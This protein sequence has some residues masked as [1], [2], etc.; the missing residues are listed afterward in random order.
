MNLAMCWQYLWYS[1]IQFIDMQQKNTP[2]IISYSNFLTNKLRIRYVIQW[3]ESDIHLFLSLYSIS[4]SLNF[5]NV[6]KCVVRSRNVVVSIN[7]IPYS[8]RSHRIQRR[9]TR[10][11][12]WR[13]NNK[14][15][16]SFEWLNFIL[17]FIFRFIFQ[18]EKRKREIKCGINMYSYTDPKYQSYTKKEEE[19][20]KI[21]FLC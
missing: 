9:K 17:S 13:V 18:Y 3:I 11:K 19:E 14:N 20:K 6:L 10:Q 12:K 4:E 21:K 2:E 7:Y 8:A 16:I 5:S 1:C 15:F